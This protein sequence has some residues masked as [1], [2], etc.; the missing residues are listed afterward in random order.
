[1]P[2]PT[3]PPGSQTTRQL[4]NLPFWR[5][6]NQYETLW[7]VLKNCLDLTTDEMTDKIGEFSYYRMA[8]NGKIFVFHFKKFDM[9]YHVNSFTERF[10]TEKMIVKLNLLVN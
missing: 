8:E 4:P 1:M 7:L 3:T 6:V 10:P 5:A 9:T 2:S